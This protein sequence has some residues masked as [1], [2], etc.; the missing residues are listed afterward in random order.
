MIVRKCNRKAKPHYNAYK[1]LFSN[2]RIFLQLLNSFVHEDFVKNLTE[3]GLELADKSFVSQDMLD[4][5]SDLLYKINING[6]D[7]YIYILIEFQS[8]PDK[9]IPV[10]MFQYILLL[11][12]LLLKNNKRG[13]LPNV[14]PLLLYNGSKKWNVPRNIRDLINKNMPDRFIP[15]Y[16][17]FAVI[18]YEVSDKYL[19][20]LSNLIAA[21]ILMENAGDKNKLRIAIDRIV[22]YIRDEDPSDIRDYFIWLKNMFS[23]EL[24][25]TKLDSIRNL[26][27]V[28]PML[29]ELV[30][31]IKNE[32]WNEGK[33]EGKTE[34][35]RAMLKDGFSVA[36]ISKYTGL[37][38][39]EITAIK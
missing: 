28:K 5:E 7:A 4:R 37:S 3:E 12:D 32:N 30:E 18:L 26:M 20:K 36:N 17:Y 34:T 31:K 39:K 25:D 38:E 10:R 19:D 2:K 6:K 11:Y 29:A 35:A 21:V 15:S 33:I 1:Y 14:F 22:M 13:L 9:A 23:V 8:T 16:E 24:K 27:E